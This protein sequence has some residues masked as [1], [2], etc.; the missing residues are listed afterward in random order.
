MGDGFIL[1]D[2]FAAGPGLEDDV[3]PFIVSLYWRE[4]VQNES[5]VLVY[6][7]YKFLCAVVMAGSGRFR[8]GTK[9]ALEVKYLELS[10]SLQLVPKR[11]GANFEGP[12]ARKI[13]LEGV[14]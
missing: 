7:G 1:G 4:G 9:S 6:K 3:D 5:F 12:I 14:E 8:Y 2:G 13:V 10:G 11:Q